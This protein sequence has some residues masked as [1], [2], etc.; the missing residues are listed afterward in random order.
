RKGWS[1]RGTRRCVLQ[2][3]SVWTLGTHLP[4][5]GVTAGSVRTYGP[6]KLQVC[7]VP[8]PCRASIHRWVDTRLTVHTDTPLRRT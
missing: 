6:S 7:H 4:H 8:H 1:Q 2:M 5:L 3:R